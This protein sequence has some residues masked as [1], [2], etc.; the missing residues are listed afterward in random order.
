MVA[1]VVEE[2]C[3]ETESG[4]TSDKSLA[5]RLPIFGKAY[6]NPANADRSQDLDKPLLFLNLEKLIP[7]S[8]HLTYTNT[9]Y[10]PKNHFL[11]ANLLSVQ[12]S[13]LQRS[14]NGEAFH[15]LG[16][17]YRFTNKGHHHMQALP[18]NIENKL[19]NN[20]GRCRFARRL[21]S[22]PL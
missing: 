3:L 1:M 7:T 15:F 21:G 12:H 10:D 18:S 20:T 6:Y 4:G 14:T 17:P 19:T 5:E 22:P 16:K 8:Y 2:S 11:L 13:A 9:S